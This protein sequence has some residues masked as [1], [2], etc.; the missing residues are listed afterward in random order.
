MLRTEGML[1]SEKS[2]SRKLSKDY[3][4]SPALKTAVNE[5]QYWDQ[6]LKKAKGLTVNNNIL[7]KL[8]CSVSI[9]ISTLPEPLGVG[10]SPAGYA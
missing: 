1:S 7:H 6:S 3:D 5:Y 9:V 4:W 10:T 8:Q 2:V